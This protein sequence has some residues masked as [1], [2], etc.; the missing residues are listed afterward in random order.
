[1]L[2]LDGNLAFLRHAWNA[3]VLQLI[4][5]YRMRPRPA[6]FGP[7]RHAQPDQQPAGVVV[8]AVR[9]LATRVLEMAGGARNPVVQRPESGNLDFFGRGNDPA[10]AE[11][12]APFEELRQ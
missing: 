9:R 7:A 11:Q 10:L 8:R 3:M 4:A 5:V 1:F 12:R 6:V 2:V